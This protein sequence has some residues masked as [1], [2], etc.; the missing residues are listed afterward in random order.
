MEDI[1]LRLATR[2]DDDFLFR[3][4]AAGHE[5]EFR[6]AGIDNAQITSLLEMQY[7]IRK[8]QYDDWY[9]RS[10]NWIILVGKNPVGRSLIQR[11]TKIWMLVDIAVLPAH[12]NSGIGTF[13][14]K[15]QLAGCDRDGI[16]AR[17]HVRVDNPAVRLYQRLGFIVIG[18]NGMYC[19]MERAARR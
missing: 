1:A 8:K 3:L 19:E 12:Q 14:L 11:E 17:L 4:Y 2:N 15:S 5:S 16:I 7:A 10:E 13:V 9:G 6:I 18:N